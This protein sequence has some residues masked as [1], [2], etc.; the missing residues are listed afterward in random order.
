MVYDGEQ[1]MRA[2]IDKGENKF[3]YSSA[4]QTL[5]IPA[6]AGNATLRFYIYPVSGE[7]LVVAQR[8][9]FPQ[10]RLSADQPTATGDAQYLLLIDEEEHILWPAL[11]WE[12]SNA[13]RWQPHR[14]DLT[15]CAGQTLTL[16][17]GV[18][19]D[20]TG[21]R[22]AMYVDNVSLIVTHRVYLPLILKSWDRG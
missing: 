12:L 18:R 4:S 7:T 9:A 8:R 10:G 1:S 21:G 5:A 6:D 17:F 22:T 19:N 13:Q 14:Y 20:G 11:F 2:G 16:H 15:S 3:S